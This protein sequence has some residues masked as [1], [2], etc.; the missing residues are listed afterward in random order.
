MLCDYDNGNPFK[1]YEDFA[2]DPDL[3]STK[4]KKDK[5]K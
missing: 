5:K 4:K 3:P 1:K 2:K